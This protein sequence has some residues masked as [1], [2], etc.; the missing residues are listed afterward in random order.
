MDTYE[1]ANASRLLR[2]AGMK[3]EYEQLTDSSEYTSALK[4]L[5]KAYADDRQHERAAEL[6][7][8]YARI[9][10]E[11]CENSGEPSHAHE[12]VWGSIYACRALINMLDYPGSGSRCKRGT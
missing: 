5:A 8:E 9:F 7:L 2:S 6:Y 3:K 11:K 1:L 10:K 12:A 4:K